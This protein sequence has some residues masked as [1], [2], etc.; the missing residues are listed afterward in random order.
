MRVHLRAR[1][2][3]GGKGESLLAHH[4]GAVWIRLLP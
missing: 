2:A 3:S 1:S 4:H